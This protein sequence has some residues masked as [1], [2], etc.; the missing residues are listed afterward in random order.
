MNTSDPKDPFYS[1]V[2]PDF[3]HAWNAGQVYRIA[4]AGHG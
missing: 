4:E 2:H 1:V 3:G